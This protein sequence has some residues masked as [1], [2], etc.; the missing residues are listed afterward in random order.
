MDRHF[1]GL[2]VVN[3]RGVRRINKGVYAYPVEL[4][5]IAARVSSMKPVD[6]AAGLEIH[7]RNENRL[8]MVLLG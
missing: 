8:H 6:V 1:L 5:N 2:C 7:A 4:P 3:N